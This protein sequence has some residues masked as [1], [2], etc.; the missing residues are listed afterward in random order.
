MKL[1]AIDTRSLALFRI[2][3]AAVVLGDLAFRTP[4]ITFFLTDV[5]T[6]PR[7]DLWRL[8]PDPYS[9]SLHA[10]SGSWAWQALLFTLHAAAALALG[11]GWRTRWATVATW[12]LAVS[13]QDRN[14]QILQGGDVL[15]RCLL[16][17]AM[18]LPLGARWSLDARKHGDGPD[19]VR[20]AGSVAIMLQ[21]AGMYLCSGLLKWHP[22]WHS[23]GSALWYA[24]HL[25]QFATPLGC[26]LRAHESW[27][28]WLGRG[29]LV[30]ELT[31]PF[32]AFIPWRNDW[33]RSAA[34]L[35]F[36]GF[37]IGLLLCLE[38]GP[39]PYVCIAAWLLFIPTCWWDR[40]RPDPARVLVTA[41]PEPWWR[42]TA[43]LML[44]AY[45]VLWNARTISFERVVQVFPRSANLVLEI[46]RLDQM[47]SMFA[48]FPLHDDGWYVA[49]A[50]LRDGS[51]VDL[52]TGRAP[53]E[54]QPPGP[55]YANERWRKYLMNL[56]L[57]ENAGWRP[58][59]MTAL[60]RRWNTAH[61][62][63]PV[64]SAELR[65]WRKTNHLGAPPTIACECLAKTP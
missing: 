13:L 18:F 15:L 33:F 36:V 56:Y 20:S 48:P 59:A 58:T 41:A 51:Q 47:W 9:W 5:G 44:L 53:D 54:H 34:V 12:V 55:P 19:V 38:L 57:A 6:L 37:H 65:F 22:A 28:P 31:G 61:P 8:D 40:L 32:L 46:P 23:E 45:V 30:L 64:T 62:G 27:L 24:L 2:A 21:L 1:F 3:I 4:D 43:L 10:L 60:V 39:F 16:F 50:T 35:G 14:Y 49:G 63:N 29:T 52:I 11:L 26:W 7:A 17:W 42:E 25:D